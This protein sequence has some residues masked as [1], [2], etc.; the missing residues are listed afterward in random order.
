MNKIKFI[1]FC[2]IA[3]YP[4]SGH[5]QTISERLQSLGGSFSNS[6]SQQFLHPDQAFLLSITEVNPALLRANVIIVDGY[7]L[8]HDKFTFQFTEGH[9]RVNNDSIVIPSGKVKEDP[10]FGRVEVNIGTFDIY[11]P[12]I[13]DNPGQI[14]VTLQYGYQ[15]CK[16][17]SPLKKACNWSC[18]Q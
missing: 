6:P 11:I 9:T 8:Y 18:Q 17:N 7:Y 12:I 16:D 3:L 1:V 15:G 13:R 14:P 4:V 2:L 5:V 10:S